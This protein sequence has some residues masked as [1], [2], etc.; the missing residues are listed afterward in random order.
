MEKKT[1]AE[2]HKFI[3]WLG[4]H[5]GVDELSPADIAGYAEHITPSEAKPIRS[6]LAYICKGGFTKVNLASHLRARKASSKVVT[7][8]QGPQR[9]ATLTTQGYTKLEVEL[10]NLK[11]RRSAVIEEVRK[12]AA[13]KDFREN[14]PLQAAREQKAHLEGRIEELESTLSSARIMGENQGALRIKM[15]DTV[16]LY[17]L[18]SSKELCY[19]LVD[20]REANPTKG[21]LSVASPLG[22]ALLDKE[23]GQSVEVAAPAGIF[24]YRI[25]GIQH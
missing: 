16:I 21:K 18:S 6:F 20:P 25:E 14:A 13:D 2:V 15:G 1:Q 4:L 11:N 17:D 12:A 23:K 24:I 3:R 9:Q 8:Q 5:R 7:P 22:K 10:T 19:V